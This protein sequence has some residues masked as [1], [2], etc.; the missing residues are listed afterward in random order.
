MINKITTTFLVLLFSFSFASA[1]VISDVS[2]NELFPGDQTTLKVEIKNTLDDDVEDVSLNLILDNVPFISIGGSEES[3][4]EIRDGRTETFSFVIKA[5]QDIEPGD[6]SIPYELN[7]FDTKEDETISKSGSIGVVVS[8]KTE[9]DYS[10]EIKNNVVGEQGQVTLKIINSGFGDIKFVNVKIFPE[11]FTLLG[12]ANDY[13]GTINSDDF[14]SA[15]YDVLFNDETANLIATVTYKDFDNNEES[16]TVNLPLTVYSREKAI[17]LGIIEKNNSN[18]Y[19]GIIVIIIILW[20]IYR[21]IKKRKRNS[22]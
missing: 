13:V 2:Q 7:Y 14:E 9:L 18:L 21:R 19:V 10:A 12:S 16:I 15:T 22:K 1:V 17:E 8:A 6:Y 5:S 11:G 3:E 20:F 4:D